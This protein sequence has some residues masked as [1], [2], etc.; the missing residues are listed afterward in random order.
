MISL[1]RSF[2]TYL[3][4]RRTFPHEVRKRTGPTP[5]SGQGGGTVLHQ[6][7][8]PTPAPLNPGASSCLEVLWTTM[9]DDYSS[10]LSET[11]RIGY[12]DTRRVGP[13]G[14]AHGTAPFRLTAKVGET[15]LHRGL[16]AHGSTP[17]V[18]F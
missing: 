7:G 15:R 5:T 13:F 9:M 16:T 3:L 8:L 17:L 6:V 12:L 11:F 14:L 1:G 18:T 10:P 4:D 2:C